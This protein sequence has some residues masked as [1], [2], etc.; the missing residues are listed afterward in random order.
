MKLQIKGAISSPN[1]AAANTLEYLCAQF[2]HEIMSQKLLH[3]NP[4]QVSL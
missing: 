2:V 3:A 1:F 4:F